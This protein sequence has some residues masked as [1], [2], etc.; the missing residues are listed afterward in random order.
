MTAV[1]FSVPFVK[2]DGVDF[3]SLRLV[4]QS[5]SMEARFTF[6]KEHNNAFQ[7]GPSGANAR[8]GN[9]SFCTYSPHHGWVLIV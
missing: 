8:K 2:T 1:S 3:L 9:G 7:N 4:I 5:N 6:V